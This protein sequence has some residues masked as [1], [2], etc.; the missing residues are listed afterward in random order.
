MREL[1]AR[2]LR[3]GLG[4]IFFSLATEVK[5]LTDEQST[6]ADGTDQGSLSK[7]SLSTSGPK[8]AL[9]GQADSRLFVRERAAV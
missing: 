1:Y 4:D 8:M 2:P 9:T 7:P 3:L 5:P 6:Y